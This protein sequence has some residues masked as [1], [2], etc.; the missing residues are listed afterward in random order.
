MSEHASD[1]PLRVAHIITRLCQGGAQE[2]TFHTIRLANRERFQCDLISGPT[3]GREGSIEAAITEAG[4]SIQRV[5][6]LIRTPSPIHDALAFDFRIPERILV[7][8]CVRIGWVEC[9]DCLGGPFWAPQP[10]WAA[11]GGRTTP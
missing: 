2:N 1:R 10:A 9:D 3:T 8:G 6:T 5:P 4:I 11:R 7:A